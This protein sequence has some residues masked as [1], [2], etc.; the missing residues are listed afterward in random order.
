VIQLKPLQVNMLADLASWSISNKVA[1][2]AI[3]VRVRQG[4][5]ATTRDDALTHHAFKSVRSG[6]NLMGP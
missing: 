2:D 3:L 4:R 6:V 5:V 1:V